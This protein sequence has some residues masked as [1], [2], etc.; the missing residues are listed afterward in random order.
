MA[1]GLILLG[2]LSILYGALQAVGTRTTSE[3]LAWSSIRRVGYILV[4]LGVDGP[5]GFSVA[6]LYIIVNAMNK[7]VL[8]L[9]VGLRGCWRGV[10]PRCLQGGRSA[11]FGRL[12]RQ[13]RSSAPV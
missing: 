13:W 10:C 5:I 4:V 2:G 3:V 12:L 11:P 6:V 8:F 1:E 9:T 7:R